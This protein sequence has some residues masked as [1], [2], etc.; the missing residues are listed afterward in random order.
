MPWLKGPLNY[1][2]EIA[3]ADYPAIRLYNVRTDFKARPEDDCVNG[4]WTVCTP[5]TV[6]NFSAAAYFFARTIHQQLQ[7]PV[8]LVV[9]SLGATS[10]QA[11]TSRDTLTANTTLYQKY[12]YPYDT[13]A[14]SKITPD[15]VVT[16]EKMYCPHFCTMR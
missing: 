16:F 8:G 6:P 13:S 7:V 15:T 4:A 1:D 12:L 2:L 14:V 10:C 5:Q 3:T 9:S 11:W